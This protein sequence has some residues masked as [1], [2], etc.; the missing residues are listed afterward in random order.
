MHALAKQYKKT[1]PQI[2][3]RFALQIG[4]LPLT[5]TSDPHHMREDLDLDAFAL[6][7]DS[8]KFIEEINKG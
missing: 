1:I 5:G 7:L 4:I 8:V 6:T 3:F 2:I